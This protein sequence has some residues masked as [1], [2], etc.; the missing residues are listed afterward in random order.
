MDPNELASRITP[1][2]AIKAMQDTPLEDADA[3]AAAT[4]KNAHAKSSSADAADQKKEE[5]EKEETQQ[6]DEKQPAQQATTGKYKYGEEDEFGWSMVADDGEVRRLVLNPGPPDGAN[7]PVLA[8]V[9]V[10][11]EGR[12]FP[13]GT[14]VAAGS[15]APARERLGEDYKQTEGTVFLSSLTE[16]VDFLVG[17]AQIAKGRFAFAIAWLLSRS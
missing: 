3:E 17:Q 9:Y 13:P 2:V 8:R 1:E 6:Q 4:R 10:N 11:V 15:K 5:K 12:F 16:Y 14:T 7:P